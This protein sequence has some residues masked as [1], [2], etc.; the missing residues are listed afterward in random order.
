MYV[1]E[2]FTFLQAS[3]FILQG[4]LQQI[5]STE[6]FWYSTSALKNHRQTA[7]SKKSISYMQVFL[8]MLWTFCLD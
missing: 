1:A 3:V 7:Y 6:Q 8:C 5:Y 4:Q 2:Q